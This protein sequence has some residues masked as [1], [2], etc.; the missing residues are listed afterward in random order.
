M[1]IMLLDL[2]MIYFIF[3][4][5]FFLHVIFFE[6]KRRNFEGIIGDP[7]IL[8]LKAIEKI[9]TLMVAARF[10]GVFFF[11]FNAYGLVGFYMFVR[12][13]HCLFWLI[14]FY[15]LSTKNDRPHDF[16]YNI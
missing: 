12:L 2:F 14:Y 10:C 9:E 8:K 5:I 11:I 13:P 15:N 7:E 16:F 1:E 4:V 6:K 3:M